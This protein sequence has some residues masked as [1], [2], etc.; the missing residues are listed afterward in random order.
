[1]KKI[2]AIFALTILSSC[3]LYGPLEYQGSYPISYFDDTPVL[4]SSEYK[5]ERS[6]P[7]GEVLTAYVGNTVVDKKIY[8]KKVFTAEEL[9]A[10]K[11]GV[12][13]SVS[14]PITFKMNE[15]KTVI[16]QVKLEDGA[17]M[18]IPTD[19]EG[20]VVLVSPKGEVFERIGQ[21]RGNRIVLLSTKHLIS[22]RSFRFEVV[23]STRSEQTRPEKG[24]DI[25]YG[26][27]K[28]DRMVFT[29]L[30]YSKLDGER[31]YFEDITFPLDQENIEIEGVGFKVL[32]ATKD[33]IDY[34]ILK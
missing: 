23:T 3:H 6:Q 2:L 25:K 10:N 14:A 7:K 20:Y 27:I 18:L 32:K 24:F 34:I 9:R 30:D 12:M 26:G 29:Y 15:K 5:E 16:G 33:K 22:P 13:S 31:G 19:I 28:L 17:F 11:N 21:I 4:I 8:R 1:M